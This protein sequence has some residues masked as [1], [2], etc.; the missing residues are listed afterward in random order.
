MIEKENK[1]ADPFHMKLKTFKCLGILK[2][3]EY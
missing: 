3:T 1:N 2:F